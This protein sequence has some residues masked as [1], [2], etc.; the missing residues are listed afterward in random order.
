VVIVVKEIIAQA[1]GI[2]EVRYRAKR[3]HR[4][5]AEDAEISQRKAFVTSAPPLRPLRLCGE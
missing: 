4:R 1:V 3:V 5:D 2:D